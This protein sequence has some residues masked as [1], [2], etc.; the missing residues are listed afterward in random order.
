MKT[1]FVLFIVLSSLLGCVGSPVQ[2]QKSV[3]LASSERFVVAS[4]NHPETSWT[5][6]IKI[7]DYDR[8]CNTIDLRTHARI[9]ADRSFVQSSKEHVKSKYADRIDHSWERLALIG[10]KDHI[11]ENMPLLEIVKRDNKNRTWNLAPR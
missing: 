3:G 10:L 5:L 1:I 2:T 7:E 11:A 8:E 4:T 9:D 6:C